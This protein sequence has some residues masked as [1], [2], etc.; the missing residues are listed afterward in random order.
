MFRL[1]ALLHFV[2]S[3]KPHTYASRIFWKDHERFYKIEGCDENECKKREVAQEVQSL[4][5]KGGDPPLRAT[6]PSSRWSFARGKIPW[7]MMLKSNRA[8]EYYKYTKR[9]GLSAWY[10][11]RLAQNN[12]EWQHAGS[13][14][15]L[16]RKKIEIKDGPAD[17][18]SQDASD[19]EHTI[20]F[21][22]NERGLHKLEFIQLVEILNFLVSD[23][24]VMTYF[25]SY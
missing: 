17:N 18:V 8:M 4:I 2:L 19:V 13:Q 21:P 11:Q 22:Q 5:L 1:G 12:R 10:C 20:F 14:E 24:E 23:S 6:I 3:K 9:D 15:G 25:D 7:Y 16:I